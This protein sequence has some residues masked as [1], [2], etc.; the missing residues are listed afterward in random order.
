MRHQNNIE[1]FRKNETDV[2]WKQSNVYWLGLPCVRFET[3]RR[4]A[5][6]RNN[7]EKKEIKNRKTKRRKHCSAC[8]IFIPKSHSPL[9]RFQYDQNDRLILC[10]ED[11]IVFFFHMLAPMRQAIENVSEN[12]KRFGKCADSNTCNVKNC[13]STSRYTQLKF[14]T[15]LSVSLYEREIHWNC[16]YN[17]TEYSQWK[18]KK[19]NKQS[20]REFFFSLLF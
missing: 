11:K 6:Q 20:R 10:S 14:I 2:W 19:K 13:M 7:D 8:L 18:E 9:D 12:R 5:L 17:W 15:F 1:S 3:S 16:A 4:W